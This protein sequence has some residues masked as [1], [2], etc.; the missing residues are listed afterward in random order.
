MPGHDEAN[1]SWCLP[2]HW[3]GLLV[4]RGML[5]VIG[6]DLLSERPW[7]RAWSSCRYL[8]IRA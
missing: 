2:G 6:G 1:V 7:R 8:S 5:R 4:A 3:Q